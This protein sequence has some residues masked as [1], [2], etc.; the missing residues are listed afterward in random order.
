MKTIGSHPGAGV[1]RFTLVVVLVLVLMIAFFYYTAAVQ[2]RVEE[3]ARDQMLAN[4]KQALSMMLYDYAIKGQLKDL[5]Q[6]DQENPFVPLAIYRELPS[7]YHGTING[8]TGLKEY[9]WYFDLVN[10]VAIYRFSDGELPVQEYR[11]VFEFEDLDGNG[12][13]GV[14]DTGYL[15]IKR[16]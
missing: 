1:F 6:F 7:N 15:T 13:Y 9:G 3:V 4:M 2:R 16:A 12:V 14:G 5:Q 10:R 11:M 8:E